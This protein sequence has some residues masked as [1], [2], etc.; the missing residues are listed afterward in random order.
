[1]RVEQPPGH[2]AVVRIESADPQVVYVPTYDPAV[3]YG[4]WAYPAYPPYTYYPYGYVATAA[5]AFTAGVAL[6]R[7]L[8][9]CLGGMQLAEEAISTLTPTAT[10][11]STA[12]STAS[13]TGGGVERAGKVG[14]APGSMIPAT[15]QW[16]L[17]SG[18][19]HGAALQPRWRC[20]GRASRE[21]FRGRAETDRQEL[22]TRGSRADRREPG[23]SRRPRWSRR[24][25]VE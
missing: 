10:P 4:A 9:I 6:E 22:E 17:V 12:T 15:G 16:R 23:R 24:P 5:L 8:G 2:N 19:R 11:I 7:G 18:S 20:P 14:E 1:M 25:Q 13:S 3:V 21:A